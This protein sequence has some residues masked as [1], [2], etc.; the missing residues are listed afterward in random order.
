MFYQIPSTY[1]NTLAGDLE[2]GC[3]TD[4]LWKHE[5]ENK[6]KRIEKCHRYED[7]FSRESVIHQ[8]EDDKTYEQND[9]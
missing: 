2:F 7:G 1:L 5:C 6:T 8:D 4:R 9:A 3:Q